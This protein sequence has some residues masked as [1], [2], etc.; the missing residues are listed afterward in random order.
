MIEGEGD[1]LPGATDLRASVKVV[2]HG[3]QVS[4]LLEQHTAEAEHE[5][6]VGWGSACVVN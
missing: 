4:G 3:C 1:R 5:G 6:G 2:N